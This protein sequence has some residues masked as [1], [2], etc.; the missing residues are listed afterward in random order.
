[1]AVAA[2]AAAGIAKADP[3]AIGWQACRLGIVAYIVPFIFMFQPALILQGTPSEVIL[4][5]I[6]G[7][8]GVVALSAAV[9][10]WLRK[11]MLVWERVLAIAA[12]LLLMYPGLFTDA[13]G[14]GLIVISFFRQYAS[15]GS[16][17]LKVGG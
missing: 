4:A 5:L 14:L 7:T 11:K 16:A 17:K 10:G 12:A 13:I 3:W 1:M 6:T 15:I 8:L 2:Y 9:E